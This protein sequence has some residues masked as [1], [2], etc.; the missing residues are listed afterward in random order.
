MEPNA[1]FSIFY[2]AS[3]SNDKVLCALTQRT[4]ISYSQLPA[5]SK[6]PKFIEFTMQK[7]LQSLPHSMLRWRR[8]KCY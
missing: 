4:A 7:T 3:L 8:K 2:G 5:F 1:M 6:W